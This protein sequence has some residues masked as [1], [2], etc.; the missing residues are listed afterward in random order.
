[1]VTQATYEAK[2]PLLKRFLAAYRDSAAWMIAKPEEA[3]KLAVAPSTAAT[4]PSISGS[5][6][7]ATRPASRRP[8]Q[9]LG[10]FDVE[11]MQQGADTFHKLGLIAETAR[12][13]PDRQDRPDPVRA[14]MKFRDRTIL[15]TGASHG[16]GA[17]LAKAF[18]AERW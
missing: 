10:H 16:I 18:A 3:A 2:K 4:R 1:M 14:P 7:C 6:S 8:T 17:A 12:H 13:E 9:G 11:L 5:S 15:V